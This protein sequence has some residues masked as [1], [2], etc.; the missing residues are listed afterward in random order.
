MLFFDAHAPIEDFINCTKNF[1][2][3][4]TADFGGRFNNAQVSVNV[5]LEK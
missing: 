1:G 2:V 4:L 5:Y 3:D